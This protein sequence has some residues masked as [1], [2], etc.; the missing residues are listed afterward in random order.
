MRTVVLMALGSALLY[1]R[2]ATGADDEK[3]TRQAWT[4]ISK[5]TAIR[6]DYEVIDKMH[7]GPDQ[8]RDNQGE[9]FPG[10]ISDP[11]VGDV[12]AGSTG[13]RYTVKS[14]EHRWSANAMDRVVMIVRLEAET[15]DE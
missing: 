5:G 2:L 4:A 1:V 14:R 13:T 11:Q 3:E 9:Q 7:G 6:V 10:W 15:P 8:P 12:V